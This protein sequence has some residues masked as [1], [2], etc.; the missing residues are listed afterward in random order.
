[1]LQ[2]CVC[3][4]P[5]TNSTACSLPW[6]LS[7]KNSVWTKWMS[8]KLIC[9]ITVCNQTKWDLS[10]IL[11]A[12]IIKASV[13]QITFDNTLSTCL[14]QIDFVKLMTHSFYTIFTLCKRKN[15]WQNQCKRL[16]YSVFYG[17][18]ST[19]HECF[20]SGAQV[21]LHAI[22]PQ[23]PSIRHSSPSQIKTSRAQ[24]L[25][26]AT[27]NQ[28]SLSAC[29]TTLTTPYRH[30][31]TGYIGSTIVPPSFWFLNLDCLGL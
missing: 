20:A 17:K 12:R 1:M 13:L 15:R 8:A 22:P 6:F 14:K 10:V 30:T 16:H 5:N 27:S 9:Q 11:K 29:K 19:T 21:L 2:S 28:C 31:N 4:W 25:N 23:G 26:Q 7:Q 24:I 3:I 18:Q